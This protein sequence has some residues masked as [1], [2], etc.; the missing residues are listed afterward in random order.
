MNSRLKE[1]PYMY[2]NMLACWSRECGGEAVPPTCVSSHDV[3]SVRCGMWGMLP[4]KMLIFTSCEVD[5]DVIL[6]VKK[7]IFGT[8]C[9]F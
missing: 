4:H 8:T 1:L 6:E 3:V 7:H 2:V 9:I 5:S